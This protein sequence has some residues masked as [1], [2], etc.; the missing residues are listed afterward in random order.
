MRILLDIGLL[1]VH[2]TNRAML[3][4]ALSVHPSRP[5]DLNQVSGH[6]I[7]LEACQHSIFLSV[8][9]TLEVF[10]STVL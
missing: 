4:D 1:K 3:Y 2:Q 7:L 9:A 10:A 8:G 5:H 6:T